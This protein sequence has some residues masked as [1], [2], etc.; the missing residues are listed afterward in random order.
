[1]V[2]K[3]CN[4]NFEH[5]SKDRFQSIQ[6]HKHIYSLYTT[7][8]EWLLNTV[9]SWTV[10]NAVFKLKAIYESYQFYLLV[11]W[12]HWL[13][14]VSAVAIIDVAWDNNCCAE[15][16]SRNIRSFN[17]CIFTALNF[18]NVSCIFCN[19]SSRAWVV[20]GKQDQKWRSNSD[21]E[22]YMLLISTSTSGGRVSKQRSNVNCYC[23]LFLVIT[24]IK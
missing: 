17:C 8:S 11:R 23:S 1:M 12:S 18:C 24:L 2:R 16:W 9:C 4:K 6:L 13:Y 7:I 19:L 20:G 22:V 5:V 15:R 21:R 14:L 10:K 3:N